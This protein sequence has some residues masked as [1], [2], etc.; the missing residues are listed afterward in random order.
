MIMLNTNKNSF[1]PEKPQKH[2]LNNQKIITQDQTPIRWFVM[3]GR[4]I[5]EFA[6]GL[7]IEA[8]QKKT[9]NYRMAMRFILLT[10][11][12]NSFATSVEVLD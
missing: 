9:T 2:G 11:D 5:G 10:F 8:D 3:K 4:E 7:I 12:E 6:I 1:N